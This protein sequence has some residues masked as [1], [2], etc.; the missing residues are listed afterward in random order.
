MEIKNT[1]KV[2]PILKPQTK[3]KYSN[4]PKKEQ[5]KSFLKPTYLGRKVD[6][7]A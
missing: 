4:P 1:K 3:F 2:H 7:Y 6:E 5:P